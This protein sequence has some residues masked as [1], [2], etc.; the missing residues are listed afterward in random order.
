MNNERE[1]FVEGIFFENDL[2]IPCAGKGIATTPA[3]T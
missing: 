3:G 1:S 2:R